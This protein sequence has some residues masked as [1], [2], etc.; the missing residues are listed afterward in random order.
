LPA[1]AQASI[2]K[3]KCKN[4]LPRK[5]AYIGMVVDRGGNLTTVGMKLYT[6]GR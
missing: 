1:A 5:K 6:D 2:R 3:R 4:T